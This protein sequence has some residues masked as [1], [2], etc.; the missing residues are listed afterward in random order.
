MVLFGVFFFWA[1]LVDLRHVVGLGVFFGCHSS[2]GE[3]AVAQGL[4]L[5]FEVDTEAL[6]AARP[7]VVLTQDLCEVC[8]VSKAAVERAAREVLGTQAHIVSM[9]PMRLGEVW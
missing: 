3:V 4:A 2:F 6:A 7:T 8:A 1:E 9:S 5:F